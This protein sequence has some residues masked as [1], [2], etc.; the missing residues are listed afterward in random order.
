M[1]LAIKN[2]FLYHTH[3]PKSCLRREH[4]TK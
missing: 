2:P 3:S 4:Y 1:I